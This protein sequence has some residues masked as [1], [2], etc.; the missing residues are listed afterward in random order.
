M[1][2]FITIA[3]PAGVSDAV[4]RRHSRE[5]LLIEPTANPSAIA[6]ASPRFVPLLV[7]FG[8]CSCGFYTRLQ[9]VQSK[10]KAEQLLAR[11]R[12]LGWSQAKIDRALASRERP[13]H[14]DD[15]LHAAMIE[16]LQTIVQ[17]HGPISVWV[18]DCKGKV[19]TEL[20]EVKRREHC[21]ADQLP[22]C[23]KR[24]ETDVLLTITA[25]AG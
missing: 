20:Y 19:E 21:T 22:E 12:R 8:G 1:C 24:L 15:G 18:H 4:R 10:E 9:P 14:P 7:T 16:L 25:A 6:A 11:Y 3:V 23:A 17:E 13:P 5:G 2:F